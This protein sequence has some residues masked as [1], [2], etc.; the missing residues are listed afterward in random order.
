VLL[1]EKMN[2]KI[3][4]FGLARAFKIGQNEANIK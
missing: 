2:P 4:D 3:L 1:D